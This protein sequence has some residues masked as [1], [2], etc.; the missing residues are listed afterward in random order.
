MLDVLTTD[1]VNARMESLAF[2]SIKI[3]R[4]VGA[5]GESVAGKNPENKKYGL[6]FSTPREMVFLVEKLERGEVVNASA[7]NEMIDLVKR[8]QSRF[9]IGRGRWQ[10]PMASKY[11]ALDSLRSA[12][13]I[14]YTKNGRL[15]LSITVGRHAR[16]Q[17]VRRESDYLLISRFSQTLM[18]ELLGLTHFLPQNSV[19]KFI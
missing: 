18:K 7:S 13:G 12:V 10:V 4:K 9:A 1:A 14:L 6:G 19:Q 3:L 15:A 2:K 11:G 17:L 5:G 16:S 8:E